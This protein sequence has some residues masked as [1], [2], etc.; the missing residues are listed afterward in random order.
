ML[1]FHSSNISQQK[2]GASK[3]LYL[4]FLC[5]GNRKLEKINFLDKARHSYLHPKIFAIYTF[6]IPSLAL[7][8]I[9]GR[10][11]LMTLVIIVP[12]GLHQFFCH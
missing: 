7:V 3:K 8:T 10:Q 6:F 11:S 12:F 5:K 4:K 2:S 1:S 9:K